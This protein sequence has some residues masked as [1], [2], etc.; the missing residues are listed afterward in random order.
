[1]RTQRKK[2]WIGVIRLCNIWKLLEK[3]ELFLQGLTRER[4]VRGREVV[5]SQE[6]LPETQHRDSESN[7][8][9]Q[10]QLAPECSGYVNSLLKGAKRH[11]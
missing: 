5:F 3:R 2:G 7:D 4:T 11:P 8:G 9:Q 1:M 10:R 6:K